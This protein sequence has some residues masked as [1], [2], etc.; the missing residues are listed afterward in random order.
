MSQQQWQRLSYLAILPELKGAISSVVVLVVG[1]VFHQLNSGGGTIV[2]FYIGAAALALQSVSQI[3]TVMTTRI[4]V[5]DSEV[6]YKSGLF[7]H[8]HKT[9][10]RKLVR[11]VDSTSTFLQRLF[12]LTSVTIGA[13]D[14]SSIE[15]VGVTRD[16]ERTLRAQLIQKSAPDAT[17]GATPMPTYGLDIPAQNLATDFGLRAAQP[18]PAQ[19]PPSAPAVASAATA[20]SYVPTGPSA[21]PE[22]P[23]TPVESASSQTGPAVP[24]PIATGSS[25]ESA[26][27]LQG[28]ANMGP[29]TTSEATERTITALNW[30]WL[31]YA[32]LTFAPLIGLG[33][34]FGALSQLQ[35][36]FNFSTIENSAKGIIESLYASLPLA[37][38]IIIGVLVLSCIG[39]IASMAQFVTGWY[40]YKLTDDG[41]RISL[42]RGLFTTRHLSI[43][44]SRIIGIE[45]SE[46]FLAR[47]FK[48]TEVSL[49][50]SGLST[51]ADSE[52][53]TLEKLTP[54]VDRAAAIAIGADALTSNPATGPMANLDGLLAGLQRRSAA[55]K[56]RRWWAALRWMTVGAAIAIGASFIPWH[57][58][59]QILMALGILLAAQAPVRAILLNRDTKMAYADGMIASRVGGWNV[60]TEIVHVERIIAWTTRANWFQRRNNLASLDLAV[61][62]KSNSEIVL[63]DLDQDVI[64]RLLRELNLVP[65]PR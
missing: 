33:F 17:P 39:V 6:E 40:G 50:A 38:L 28:A 25:L 16:V 48:S 3:V 4:R 42:K 23:E 9:I 2:G 61:A 22:G 8:K 52:A 7:T 15:L 65:Q 26:T 57:V 56:R 20:A 63:R 59:P 43:Q 27:G 21:V 36:V 64:D 31:L 1:L 47:L 10:A 35:H 44:R 45:L 60:S 18:A 30:K 55:A 29:N 14:D 24:N 13:A 58:V 54:R 49:I 46:Y 11:R 34:V 41:E 12:S 53:E 19:T 62:A 5:T 32:P 37:I 51:T